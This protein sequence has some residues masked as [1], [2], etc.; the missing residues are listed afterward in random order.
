MKQNPVMGEE[1]QLL[2]LQVL[3]DHGELSLLLSHCP[4]EKEEEPVLSDSFPSP[5]QTSA[6]S[7]SRQQAEQLIGQMQQT[8]DTLQAEL[9]QL[10]TLLQAS[11]QDTETTP[12]R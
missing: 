8:I 3:I 7:L 11:A 10:R 6:L 5:S 12:S 9:Q 1:K 2:K 4:K